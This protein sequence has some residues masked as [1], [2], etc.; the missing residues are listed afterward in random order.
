MKQASVCLTPEQGKKLIAKAIAVLPDVV[1]TVR[2]G[3]CVVITGTTNRYVA[4]ELLK[5]IGEDASLPGFFRGVTVP[6]G[7]K[8]EAADPVEDVVIVKGKRVRGKTVFDVAPGMGKDDLIFKGANAVNLETGEAAVLV[9]N[10]AL[11]TS[12]PLLQASYGRRVPVIIPVGVEKRVPAPIRML[13]EQVRDPDTAG[14]H[15]LPLPGEV[16]TELDALETLYDLE[17]EIIASGGVMGAEGA[18]YFLVSGEDEDV[19]RFI[20]DAGTL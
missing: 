10:P 14:L 9:G 2:K 1:E 17:A 19:D 3:T 20:K 8:A 15:M 6:R 5:L 7:V 4:E 18:V 12:L 11:G 16:F 13:A